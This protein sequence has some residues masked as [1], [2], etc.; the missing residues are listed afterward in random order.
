MGKIL[1]IFYSTLKSGIKVKFSNYIKILEMSDMDVIIL[2]N[3]SKYF[4]I[5]D[6]KKKVDRK[7]YAVK[8]VS[9]NIKRG[10]ALGIIGKNGSGKTTLLRLIAGILQP[11]SGSV[12]VNGKIMSFID[13]YAGF[14]HELTGRD[15]IFLYGALLGFSKDHVRK[16]MNKIIE[17][18]GLEDFIDTPLRTYS[19]GMQVR[20]AFSVALIDDPDVMLID[21]VLAV[22]DESFQ[23]RS[24]N[25][26]LDLKDKGK[27]IV[28]VSHSMGD[29]RRVCDRVI[30]LENGGIKLEGKPNE[31]IDYYLKNV[32]KEDKKSIRENIEGKIKQLSKLENKRNVLDKK[33]KKIPRSVFNR[34]KIRKL[35]KKKKLIEEYISETKFYLKELIEDVVSLL[36]SKLI[37]IE[38]SESLESETSK[39]TERLKNEKLKTIDEL[40]DIL[41]IKAKFCD[42]PSEMELVSKEI[43][44]LM[45]NRLDVK[46]KVDNPEL[47][48]ETL[49][50]NYKKRKPIERES[51]NEIADILYKKLEMTKGR[52]ERIKIINEL[53]IWYARELKNNE[54]ERILYNLK[55]DEILDNTKG[56]KKNQLSEINREIKKLEKDYERI[57]KK[58]IELS[59]VPENRWGSKEAEIL[60]VKF[61]NNG[62]KKSIF[63]TGD[64][65]VAKIE[66][67]A[68]KRIER[69]MFGVAIHT[70]DGVQLIGPNTTYSKKTK[71]FIEGRGSVNFV[72]KSLPL[73]KGYYLF[74]AVIYDY[75]GLKAYDHHN[76][77]YNFKVIGNGKE[78]YGLVSLPYDWVYEEDKD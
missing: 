40:K 14:Q 78:R 52:D 61:F 54:Y 34:L 17:F 20:L 67:I 15:N 2:K 63:K 47:G 6:E 4:E 36:R 65:I 60:G 46:D 76:Q 50:E 53:K 71:N 3:L 31:V 55:R 12:K 30:L 42:D 13:L 9:L 21:E 73:L 49:L 29:V 41:K 64:E 10:E 35:E 8:N 37:E 7:V 1:P 27:T 59:N 56:E 70:I 23:K 57:G 75:L 48:Y 72:I 43:K 68:H 24:F 11:S 45:L 58:L 26:I 32:Y 51:I 44:G 18:S 28:F 39:V 62:V 19:S 25:K 69:P 22:G 16:K 5:K 74:S 66:Y 77:L 38:K 33:L